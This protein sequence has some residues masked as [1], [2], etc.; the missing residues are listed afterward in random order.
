[1]F[2]HFFRTGY[3]GILFS[4]GVEKSMQELESLLPKLLKVGVSSNIAYF[5]Q[6]KLHGTVKG[7]QQ[8]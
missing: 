2:G 7:R 6:I 4:F 5:L 8:G 1:M 3:A